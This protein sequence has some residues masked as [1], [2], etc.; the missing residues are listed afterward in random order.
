MQLARRDDHRHFIVERLVNLA[1]HLQ[2]GNDFRAT[3]FDKLRTNPKRQPRWAQIADRFIEERSHP[4]KEHERRPAERHG[5][6]RVPAIP[7]E[8]DDMHASD[9]I[10]SRRLR[11]IIC[12]RSTQQRKKPRPSSGLAASHH[13]LSEYYFTLLSTPCARL[14]AVVFTASSESIVRWQLSSTSPLV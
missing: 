12:K 5:S 14:V 13:T 6:E 7:F 2:G 11:V 3:V 1:R 10:T 4:R 9:F 8:D